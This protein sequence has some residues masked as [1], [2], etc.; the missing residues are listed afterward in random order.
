MKKKEAFIFVG[1][2]CYRPNYARSRKSL[3]GFTLVELLVVIS[4]I[5]L[6]LSILMPSLRRARDQ[7]K[8]IVCRV[9]VRSISMAWLM[10]A[11][12][13]NGKLVGPDP[14]RQSGFAWVEEPLPPYSLEEKWDGIR[15]GKLFDYVGRSVKVFHCP[16]DMRHKKPPEFPAYS[17]NVPEG[18]YRS[19]KIPYGMGGP[20]LSGTTKPG[21]VVDKYTEIKNPSAKLILLEQDDSRGWN[22][23]AWYMHTTD[24]GYIYRW[25]DRIAMWHGA[26]TAL[27][28]ADGHS[29]MHNWKDKRTVE[30]KGN[31]DTSGSP[32]FQPFNPDWDYM[33]YA[34]KP[35]K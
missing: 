4:I 18:G 28:F 15:R 33:E 20:I 17:L 5:A 16:A 21:W 3:H 27:G 6:L 1:T 35:K 13:N 23:G 8:S 22:W 19:Y 10:Y 29:E 34:Y 26:K 30:F 24:D 31:W 11:D 9:N 14:Y 32:D 2:V 25:V 7:A 12:D